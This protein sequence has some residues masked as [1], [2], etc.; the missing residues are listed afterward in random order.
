MSNL[1][2][3][4]TRASSL[5]RFASKK[6]ARAE[7][8]A[9]FYTDRVPIPLAYL[10][11]WTTY[12][13]WLHGDRRGSADPAHNRYGTPYLPESN[14]RFRFERGELRHKPNRLDETARRLVESAIIEH[15]EHKAWRIRALHVR[16]NHVHVVVCCPCEPEKPLREF[17]AW[18]TR[19]LR[20]EDQVDEN[21]RVWTRHGSTRYL[22]DE[23]GVHGA[24]RYVNEEQGKSLD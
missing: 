20:A 24:I 5:S 16:T 2:L 21:T 1:A 19:R 8:R 22:F 9:F 4:S 17:K 14:S 15:A 18:A 11:T 12:G 7:A 13:T 10:I 6:E 3:A 23:T